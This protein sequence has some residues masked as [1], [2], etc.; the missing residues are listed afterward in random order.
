MRHDGMEKEIAL[1]TVIAYPLTPKVSIVMPVL[2][3]Q[4]YIAEAIE[5]IVAQSYR[6]FELIVIDDG[7]TDAT[8]ERVRAFEGDCQIRYVRHAAPL[9]IPSS[10][11]DGVRHAT[12]ELIAFLD[13]D[14]AWFPEFLQTQVSYLLEHPDVKMVHC[15][16]QT[17]D[18]QGNIIEASVAQCR[19]RTRPSGR[20]F[21]QLFMHSL[22][23]GNAVLVYKECFTR[24]GMFDES[25]RW[26]DYLMWMRIARHYR[27]DYVPKV[28]TKYRQHPSQST[29]SSS[30]A[31]AHEESVG[32][33]A[34]H[35]ILKEFPEVRQ[36]LGETLIRRRIASL[37]ADVAY[38]SLS[39]GDSVNA[40]R[41][42]VKALA[43]WKTDPRYYVLY[44]ASWL[45]P[46]WFTAVRDGWRRF[47]QVVGRKPANLNQRTI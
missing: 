22:V 44:A 43:S 34:I 20:I 7:S 26:G 13:H 14:D 5:S 46:S 16:F 10:M 8:R 29:R 23:C 25:L 35:K 47:R 17:I 12:G 32:L 41:C 40:R 6:N 4:K 9:G 30:V 27:I 15:D 28:M 42:A 18:P 11:N 39:N 1:E 33:Q 45:Q 21:P 3:G 31:R 24:L 38:S 2:N 36:E 19:G 37:Y